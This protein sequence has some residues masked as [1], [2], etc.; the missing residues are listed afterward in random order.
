MFSSISSWCDYGNKITAQYIAV[1]RGLSTLVS[2]TCILWLHK[3]WTR[4]STNISIPSL[5]YV[6]HMDINPPAC[7]WY[8]LCGMVR[9]RQR[10]IKRRRN[11]KNISK[12]RLPVL[13]YVRSHIRFALMEVVIKSRRAMQLTYLCWIWC[14]RMPRGKPACSISTT[15]PSLYMFGVF[16]WP[17]LPSYSYTY[18]LAACIDI[19]SSN[20]GNELDVMHC[21]G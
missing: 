16:Q 21:T 7:C 2:S 13:W 20:P 11:W 15:P 12:R 6:M 9:M 17:V 18:P 1:Q 10:C 19:S 8:R 14:S 5:T 3:E 4:I